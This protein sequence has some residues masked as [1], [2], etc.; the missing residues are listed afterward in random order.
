MRYGRRLVQILV[1]ERG[2]WA[3][4]MASALLMAAPLLIPFPTFGEKTL[5]DE[6]R[7]NLDIAG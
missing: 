4:C 3:V 7:I 1:A 6:A 2:L 5:R